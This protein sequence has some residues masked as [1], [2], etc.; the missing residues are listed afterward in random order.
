MKTI[1]EVK[2]KLGLNDKD[3]ERLD[4]EGIQKLIKINKDRLNVWS[5]SGYMVKE[6]EEE[7][8]HLEILLK[9]AADK[10]M[11]NQFRIRFTPYSFFV[12]LGWNKKIPP[13]D[14]K[15]FEKMKK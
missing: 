2:T 12:N 6:I 8:E 4:V 10:W 9:Y 3:L 5:I 14:L 15:I 11:I 7:I 1:E 13:G